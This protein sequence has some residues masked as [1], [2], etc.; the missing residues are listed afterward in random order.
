MSKEL[1]NVLAFADQVI[2]SGGYDNPWEGPDAEELGQD[3]LYCDAPGF[4]VHQVDCPSLYTDTPG[5][6]KQLLGPSKYEVP[7]AEHPSFRLNSIRD[8][9]LASVAEALNYSAATIRH[10]ERADDFRWE[11]SFDGGGGWIL[12]LRTPDGN[13]V[14][15]ETRP[16][17]GQRSRAAFRHKNRGAH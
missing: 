3:C 6:D 4:D 16:T 11:R 5:I 17:S 10:A 13:P 2:A 9:L 7:F 14:T 15:V 8:P 12:V 1:R